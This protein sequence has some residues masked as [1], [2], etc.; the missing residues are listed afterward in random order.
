MKNVCIKIDFLQLS[1]CWL[2]KCKRTAQP[3]FYGCMTFPDLYLLFKFY[4][5][6]VLCQFLSGLFSSLGLHR[7]SRHDICWSVY[8]V[9][10]FPCLTCN[11]AVAENRKAVKCDICDKW[12]Q[13]P[14]NNLNSYTHKNL[15][16]D[17]SPWYCICYFQKGLQYCSIDNDVLNSLLYN[18]LLYNTLLYP[19]PKFIS[20]A[21]KQSE[22]FDEEILERFNNKYYTPKEFNNAVNVLSTK[23]QNFYTHLNI[24]SLSYHH[25]ELWN[26]FSD[27]KIKTKIIEISES[28]LLQKAR[29]T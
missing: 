2:S 7:F 16:K 26:L 6:H 23:K 19:N 28:R 8:M 27:L 25:F 18:S 17:K 10:Q 11:K 1:W 3:K 22:Y 5:S 29:G 20:S 21:I 4:S 24:S 14:C 13:I 12:V 15:L 9:V